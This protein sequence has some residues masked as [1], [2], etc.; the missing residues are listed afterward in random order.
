MT[1][2]SAYLELFIQ[3]KCPDTV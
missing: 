1:F 3:G 2:I